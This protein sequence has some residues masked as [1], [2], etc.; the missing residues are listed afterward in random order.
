LES[1]LKSL[2]DFVQ[3]LESRCSSLQSDLQ[4]SQLLSAESHAA[5][6]AERSTLLSQG[7]A[8]RQTA[9]EAVSESLGSIAAIVNF[10]EPCQITFPD[11]A[12]L[13]SPGSYLSRLSE[14]IRTLANTT[15]R[16]KKG[17]TVLH[18]EKA[19]LEADLAP[20]AELQRAH[21][22]LTSEHNAMKERQQKLTT[23]IAR[24]KDSFS[25][26]DGQY[27]ALDYLY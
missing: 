17:I 18:E 6:D 1:T 3:R 22:S 23:V 21:E 8:E 12:G 7:G 11:L 19:R 5:W 9:A 20:Y 26:L 27:K 24:F 13:A 4:S 15:L 14:H 2:H 10:S 16:L 25:K